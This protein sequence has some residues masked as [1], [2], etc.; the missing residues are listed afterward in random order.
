MGSKFKWIFTLFVVFSMQFSFAQEKIVSGIVT[1]LGIPLPWVNVFVKGMNQ[2]VQ[3]DSDGKYA[4]KASVGQVLEFTLLGMKTSTVTVGASNSIN[5]V[6]IADTQ[7]LETVVVTAMGITRSS[8][9]IIYAVQ[10][11]KSADLNKG[12]N[13]S[14]AGALQ[15]KLAGVQIIPSSGAPGASS[16]IIIR[17]VRSFTGNN[18]P[19]Y[20]INS[21]PIA[22]TPDFSTGNS[23]S[24]A[25]SANRA[26]DIDPNNI[27][28]ITVLKG[29]AASALYG[30][31]A[32][33]GVIMITTKSGKSL[34]KDGNPVIT[35]SINTSFE[36]IS[37]K[38]SMQNEYAQGADGKFDPYSTQ[39]WGP[40]ISELPND[41]MYG[42]NVPNANNG[43]ILRPGMYY[44]PQRVISGLDPW[45]IPKTYN[46]IDDYF[47]IGHTINHSINIA[48][49]T[50][51][52][53]YSFGVGTASQKGIMLETSMDRYTVKAVVNTKLNNEWKTGFSVN[54]VQTK[55]DKSSS[56][57]D[58]PLPGVFAA[59]RS[60]DVKGNGFAS[61]INPYQQVFFRNN[62]FNNPYWAAKYNEFNEKTNRFY[63]NGNIQYA[64]V[65]SADGN[66]K[67]T[68]KYQVGLDSYT[69]NYRDIFEFG[70]EHDYDK[71]DASSVNLYGITTDVINSLFIVN[72][73]MNITENW[74]F[75]VL[76]GNE[77]N[78]ENRKKYNDV[79]LGLNF[80][81]WP[82]IANTRTVSSEE[83][84]R[85]LRTVGFFGNAALSYKNMLFLSGT[86]RKDIISNMPRRNRSFVYP[87]VSLGF[88]LTELEELKDDLV[89]SFVKLRSSFAEIGQAGDYL[90]NYFTRPNYSGG[91]F[92]NIPLQYPLGEVSAFIPN[93]IVYDPNLKPQNT[94]SYEFGFDL[95]FFNN[96]IGLDY[97]YSRQNVLDQIFG[98]PL[99]GSTGAVSYLTNGGKLRTDAHEV[100]LFVN[101]VKTENFEW[102]FNINFSKIDSYVDEL[103]SGVDNIRLGGFV[104]PQI[105]ASVGD[106]YPVIYGTSFVRDAKNN[107]LVDKKGLPVLGREKALGEVA[108]KFMLG[109]STQFTYK[110]WFLGATFDWKNGGKI[111]SGTNNLL[112]F[113]GVD[114]RTVDRNS[115]YIFPGVKQD[116]TPNDIAVTRAA[117]QALESR[118]QMITENNVYDAS[119]LKLR[120]ISIAFTFPKLVDEL[121]DLRISFFARNILIWSKMP[122]LDPEAS[123]GNNNMGGGFEQWSIPQ[124]KSIGL[125]LNVT[126]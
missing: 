16:Q 99:A 43:G 98:I 2:G 34:A 14:L 81:G 56:A 122:N 125:A 83:L 48:Q 59:P 29:Q 118:L 69:T 37:K 85:Q 40:K 110:R 113:Y 73:N 114:S 101:P 57:G 65:I 109:S 102:S 90:G 117:R 6:M 112:S 35:Y 104:T 38:P 62:T 93:S 96:R 105:R 77:Y 124:V 13:N 84:R 64:S 51:K 36:S 4:I 8:K 33:N 3:T 22:S 9:S 17:G 15:G 126:F 55:I 76:V 78:H 23:T 86:V 91:F 71:G 108:P 123:Q 79:G 12:A 10:E 28:S 119:F 45:V 26:V 11:V 115:E 87:S 70:N 27:E 32:S 20:V 41:S 47:K 46:N 60:Y 58:S 74:I 53:N 94:R 116:G 68:F 120:E 121:V 67:L 18:T 82:T 21:M 61:K 66:K 19:L 44:V 100:I 42:G 95:K 92:T 5:V 103:A 1:E 7:E 50:E 111:Y 39:S 88:I 54:Y 106:R 107:I 31:R 63:G 52:T 89:L 75:D 97:T 49:A 24:G 80:G 72:Y 30:M 25:D